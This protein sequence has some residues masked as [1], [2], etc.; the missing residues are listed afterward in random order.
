MQRRNEE[1]TVQQAARRVWHAEEDKQV[2]EQ[3]EWERREWKEVGRGSFNF[4]QSSFAS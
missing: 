2:E 1:T 3:E 4:C